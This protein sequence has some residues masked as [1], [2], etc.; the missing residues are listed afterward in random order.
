VWLAY[1]IPIRAPHTLLRAPRTPLRAPHTLL[2]APRT[3]LRAPHTLLRAPHTPV[4]HAAHPRRVCE[5]ARWPNPRKPPG[6]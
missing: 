6:G 5:P 1:R 2:R 3:P 4:T